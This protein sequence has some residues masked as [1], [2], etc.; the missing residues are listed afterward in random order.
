LHQQPGI[1]RL[2]PVVD[3]VEHVIVDEG[4]GAIQAG[5]LDSKA[6]VVVNRGAFH[7]QAAYAGIERNEQAVVRISID[8]AVQHLQ[9]D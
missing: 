3:V 8:G 9:T 2:E 5:N 4:R 7:I 6:G 1:L